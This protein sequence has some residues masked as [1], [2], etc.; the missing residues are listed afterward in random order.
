[1]FCFY[2][3]FCIESVPDPWS[4]SCPSEYKEWASSR[5]SLP[6]PGSQCYL[7]HPVDQLSLAIPP[8]WCAP[9]KINLDRYF[10][11]SFPD[12]FQFPFACEYW[13]GPTERVNISDDGSLLISGGI[14]C[15]FFTMVWFGKIVCH[16]KRKPIALLCTSTLPMV[17]IPHP[18][19]ES[20]ME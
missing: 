3:H 17:S 18:F 7:Q 6:H 2:G 1:M 5:E 9:K 20:Q 16:T 12:L 14:L 13:K 4:S 10:I 8:N 11:Y 15:I 19:S